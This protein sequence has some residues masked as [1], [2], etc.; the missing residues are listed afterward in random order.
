MTRLTSMENIGREIEK[1][2]E[3]V[4]IYTAEELVKIGSR[5][6]FLMLKLHYPNVCLVHLYVLEGAVL[7]IPYNQLSEETKQDLKKYSDS[8]K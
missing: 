8:L 2:L 5:K 6:A 1:K 3:A 7:D 4:E